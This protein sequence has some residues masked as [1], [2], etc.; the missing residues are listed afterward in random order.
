MCIITVRLVENRQGIIILVFPFVCQTILFPD[1]LG[2][3]DNNRT[4]KALK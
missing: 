2:I 4:I 3:H 1:H